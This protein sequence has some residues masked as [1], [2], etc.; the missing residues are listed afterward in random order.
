[1][2]NPEI[3]ICS[4]EEAVAVLKK[5][6]DWNVLSIRDTFALLQESVNDNNSFWCGRYSTLDNI[7]PLCRSSLVLYFDDVSW[8]YQSFGCTPPSEENVREILRWSQ[9]KNR[10][11]V[12]CTAGISRSSAS[13]YIIACSRM[14]P[15]KAIGYL[16]SDRH[17]PNDLI[18][19]HGAKLLD[20]REIAMVADK[21]KGRHI[22]FLEGQVY[23]EIRHAHLKK[24]RKN[25]KTFLLDTLEVLEDVLLEKLEEKE[26]KPNG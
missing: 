22:K 16:F 10:I 9:G 14:E 20:N 15:Q 25:N 12:H 24:K 17:Y 5:D 6:P 26:G 13:A 4:Y 7:L 8:D 3:R 19:D 23:Q 1:M 21:F 11:L 2:T 18:V